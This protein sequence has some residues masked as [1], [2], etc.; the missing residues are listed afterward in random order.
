MGNSIEGNIDNQMGDCN[1]HIDVANILYIQ[2][3]R[4]YG[5]KAL[6]KNN[7]KILLFIENAQKYSKGY[8][9]TVSSSGY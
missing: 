5:K 9:A 8:L 1:T 2:L 4:S 6:G 3:I 7:N